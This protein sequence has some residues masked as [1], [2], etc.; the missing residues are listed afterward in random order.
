L[1]RSGHLFT[2]VP[3]ASFPTADRRV[4]HLRQEGFAPANHWLCQDGSSQDET[5]IRRIAGPGRSFVHR[6]PLSLLV[7]GSQSVRNGV[8]VPR[9]RSHR[10]PSV[11]I[12]C[13]LARPPFSRQQP[14]DGKNHPSTLL[15]GLGTPG[16]YLFEYVKHS[17]G[18]QSF[19]TADQLFSGSEVIWHHVKRSIMDAIFGEC[20]QILRRC[21]T[22]NGDYVEEA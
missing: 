17:M 4:V 5:N 6:S 2:N 21:V 10:K 3:S 8:S 15:A 11:E 19:E 13:L 1:H 14:R 9:K 16:L 18:G 20:M 22:T 7:S 12:P